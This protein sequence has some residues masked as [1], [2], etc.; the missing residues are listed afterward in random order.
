MMAI[1][2][3][4]CSTS[5][6]TYSRSTVVCEAL[7]SVHKSVYLCNVT[8]KDGKDIVIF[9]TPE[10]HKKPSTVTLPEDAESEPGKLY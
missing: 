2:T 4:I 6:I 9:V 10:D 8:G 7:E 3:S 1:L 5:G